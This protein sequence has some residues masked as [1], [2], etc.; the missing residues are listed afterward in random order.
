MAPLTRPALQGVGASG[1][2]TGSVA[3]VE[4]PAVGTAA[5]VASPVDELL[6]TL[7]PSVQSGEPAR[8]PGLQT[9]IG[10][11][12]QGADY[13]DRLD[14]G[15]QGLKTQLSLALAGGDADAAPLQ[16]AVDGVEALW[17]SRGRDAGGQLDA[18]LQPP[19]V[20]LPARRRFRIRG[21]DVQ[22][23]QSG[24]TETLRLWLP[25]SSAPARAQL[26]G[27]NPAQAL[28]SLRDA[29]APAGVQVQVQ[30]GQLAFSVEESRWPALRDGIAI[31]GDGKRFPGGQAVHP[32]LDPAPAA[33]DTSQWRV[34]SA[35]ERRATLRTL[36]RVQGQLSQA[37]QGYAAALRQTAQAAPADG[38]DAAQAS[39]ASAAVTGAL[40][41]ADFNQ[42][43]ALSPALR[44]LH[45][46]RVRQVLSS[47]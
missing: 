21:L 14:R 33:I 38:L 17:Q 34:G 9:R 46:E 37:R 1:R 44:G 32:A 7:S 43:A 15:V 23:L 29:L 3:A 11:L 26:D 45:R 12:Q 42:V 20:D 39:A 8:E 31:Q 22:S 5:P 2:S 13:L 18:Q 16:A 41:Q 24:G 27:G 19:A 40:R 35:D 6:A 25:G 36:A 4:A 47:H 10:T 28:Q 30:G